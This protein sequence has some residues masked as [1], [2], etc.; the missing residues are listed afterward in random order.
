MAVFSDLL[1]LVLCTRSHESQFANPTSQ[2]VMYCLESIN[3]HR[4]P[5]LLLIKMQSHAYNPY[6]S[7]YHY[8]EKSQLEK[9]DKLRVVIGAKSQGMKQLIYTLLS[10][11]Y[12]PLSRARK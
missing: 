9:L 4:I 1:S 8:P 10:R 6:F 7:R 2:E 12:L 5:A 3:F 11:S